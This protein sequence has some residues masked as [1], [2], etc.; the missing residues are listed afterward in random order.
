MLAVFLSVT[1]LVDVVCAVFLAG[2][3][4][5]GCIFDA[6]LV[7]GAGEHYLLGESLL[8]IVVLAILDV[9]QPP[10]PIRLV[11]QKAASHVDECVR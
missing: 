4:A 11:P 9:Y 7:W 10:T 2:R 6:E 8:E 3:C 5:A 1:L